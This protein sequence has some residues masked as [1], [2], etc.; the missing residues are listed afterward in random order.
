MKCVQ[1]LMGL[2]AELV[3]A[4]IKLGNFLAANPKLPQAEEQLDEGLRLLYREIKYDVELLKAAGAF[5]EEK[6]YK[7][8]IAIYA[9]KEHRSVTKDVLSMRWLIVP[10]VKAVL[11]FP[12]LGKGVLGDP[13]WIKANYLHVQGRVSGYW[14]FAAGRLTYCDCCSFRSNI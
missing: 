4:N 12:S 14:L 11:L 1:E 9:E 3:R 13:T 7:D 6:L 10:I 2:V 8:V 5:V